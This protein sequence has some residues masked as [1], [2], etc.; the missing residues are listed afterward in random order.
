MSRPN[1]PILSGTLPSFYQG[2]AEDGTTAI[3]V[4]FSMNKTVSLAEVTGYSMRLK[5]TNSDVTL[6]VFSASAAD[7]VWNNSVSEVTFGVPQSILDKMIVGQYYKVQL[8]YVAKDITGYYS[9]VSVIKYTAAPSI[10][11]SGFN[12]AITN[13]HTG[14]LVGTYSNVTDPSEKVYRYKFSI[15]ENF[16]PEIETSGWLL[17]NSYADEDIKWSADNYVIKTALNDNTIYRVQYS[18]IT[19]N[20]LELKTPKYMVMQTASIDPELDA[21]VV[22]YLDYENA[23]ISVGL[24]GAYKDGKEAVASGAFILSR[25]SSDTNFSIWTVVHDFRLKGQLPSSFLFKDFTIEQ[26]VTYRYAIQQY[27]DARI[28]SNRIY[29][30]DVVAQFEDAYLYDGKRQLRIRFNPKVASFKTTYLD[31]K[32]T[33]LGSQYPFIFRNGAVAYKEFPING[34]LSYALD[35]DELFITRDELKMSKNWEFTTDI[36]DENI[37]YE[38]RFKL[39]VLNWLN[40]GGIKL[41]KSPAE[42]NYLVRLMNVSLTPVDQVSRMLHNFT[43]TANEVAAFNV[44][45]LSM[46]NFLNIETT[47]VGQIRW[48]SVLFSDFIAS[49]QQAGY[50]L[51]EISNIENDNTDL[52]KGYKCYH[53]KISDAVPGTKIGIGR[54]YVGTKAQSKLEIVI[55]VT[56]SYEVNFEEPE[57]YLYIL[58]PSNKMPGQVTY[59][60]YTTTT[61]KFDTIDKIS[62][63]DVS[64]LQ[65]FGPSENILKEYRDLKHEISRLYFARFSSLEVE[66]VASLEALEL[67]ASKEPHTDILYPILSNEFSPYKLYYTLDTKKYYKYNTN[68]APNID[69]NKQKK[70]FIEVEDYSTDI[71]YGDT[72]L[73]V[74]NNN[75]LYVPEL[76]GNIPDVIKIGSGV[77]AEVSFQVKEIRYGVESQIPNEKAEYEKTYEAYRAAVSGYKMIPNG[78]SLSDI[79]YCF[80]FENNNFRPLL[81][82]EK[83][84]YKVTNDNRVWT[85]ALTDQGSIQIDQERINNAYNAYVQARQHFLRLLE[86]LVKTQEVEVVQ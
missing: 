80:I 3:V 53:L 15:F 37:T 25:A 81:E 19:N 64:L 43:C 77:M 9:S 69:P 40:D 45:N 10:N 73:S 58:S 54:K 62:I 13:L 31:S 72:H 52:L 30:P 39:E 23:C 34:L 7:L 41:F 4:P 44:D 2:N 46:Y 47:E 68:Y 59:G 17:H 65:T 16:G 63:Y 8:A 28:Y 33:T 35:N 27:N 55:G 1:P 6:G 36:I 78:T 56:G 75:D 5:T 70:P 22:A 60:I 29:A 85:Y 20:N 38:R 82:S 18:V 86:E 74:E 66:P 84:G 71:L 12:P 51:N 49:K 76:K 24:K 21:D 57:K 83:D 42:G 79:K 32:K 26:G 61:N 11:I 67:A 50:S 14:E 48:Q